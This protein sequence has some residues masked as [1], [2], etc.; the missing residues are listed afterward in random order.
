MN[1]RVF[2]YNIGRFLSVDPVIQ[3]PTSTQPINPYS[4]I[5]NNPL[6]GSDPIGYCAS[7]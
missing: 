3:A 4:Y 1:G 6:A 7:T 2:D 5:M